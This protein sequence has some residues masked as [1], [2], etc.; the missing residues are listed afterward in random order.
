MKLTMLDRDIATSMIT[1]L[2]D[3]DGQDYA[4]DRVAQQFRYALAELDL[5]L[6]RV[7]ELEAACRCGAAALRMYE[8]ASP[9]AVELDAAAQG[10]PSVYAL[11]GGRR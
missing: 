8:P 5:A 1:D 2:D 11:Q 10:R 3:P 7:V 4:P 9:T 6:A